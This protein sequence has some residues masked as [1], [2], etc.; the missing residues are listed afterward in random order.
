[1]N[2]KVCTS[3]IETSKQSNESN[4][5]NQ[6]K[7]IQNEGLE[8]FKKKIKIMGMLLPITELLVF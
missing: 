5:V 6:M 8:L 7:K 4:R 2:D 1:M 3:F